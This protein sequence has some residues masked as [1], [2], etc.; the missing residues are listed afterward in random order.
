MIDDK[1]REFKL[2]PGGVI[3]AVLVFIV[4]S[5]VTALA[6]VGCLLRLTGLPGLHWLGHAID[7]HMTSPVLNGVIACGERLME[8]SRG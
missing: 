5:P 3:V 6:I 8:K 1:G 4:L 2:H 7:K